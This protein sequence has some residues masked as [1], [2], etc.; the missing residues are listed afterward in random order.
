MRGIV[1]GLSSAS[2][3]A[4]QV[5]GVSAVQIADTAAAGTVTHPQVLGYGGNPVANT[6]VIPARYAWRSSS[7]KGY[8]QKIQV[9][10]YVYQCIQDGSHCT[11]R[12]L[13]SASG[14]YTA[15]PSSPGVW[16][17]SWSPSVATGYNYT[18]IAVITWRT[19]NNTFIGQEMQRYN[20]D[21]DYV[22]KTVSCYTN[23]M[24]DGIAAIWI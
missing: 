17:G 2:L 6:L 16:L 9:D 3:L 7:Y 24:A 21:G 20:M 14:V 8:A 11:W 18:V 22:C 23:V 4:M 1:V 19:L 15:A 12:L 13:G 10:Y 5:S